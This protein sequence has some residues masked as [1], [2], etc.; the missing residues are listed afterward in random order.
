[1]ELQ[2]WEE[3]NASRLRD[4]VPCS[5]DKYSIDENER[6]VGRIKSCNAE[7]GNEVRQV[8]T[9]PVD[10]TPMNLSAWCQALWAVRS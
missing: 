9:K 3:L 7:S 1:M 5:C 4:D 2:G 10:L 6:S 8:G